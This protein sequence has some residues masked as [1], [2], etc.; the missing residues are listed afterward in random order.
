MRT[1]GQIL[2]PLAVGVVLF[3]IGQGID[4]LP[5]WGAI[6][7]SIVAAIGSGLTWHNMTQDWNHKSNNVRKEERP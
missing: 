4:I 7:I 3:R 6:V 1:I 5:L 2:I